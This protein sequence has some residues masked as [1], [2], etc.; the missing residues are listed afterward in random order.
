MTLIHRIKI[1][2]VDEEGNVISEEIISE[3][4]IV[5]PKS[6]EDIGMVEDEQTKILQDIQNKTLKSLKD[7]L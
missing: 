5:S 7:L 3:K 1:E 4:R 2:T 6:I